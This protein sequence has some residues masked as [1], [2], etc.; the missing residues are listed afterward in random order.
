VFSRPSRFAR[1][2]RHDERFLAVLTSDRWLHLLHGHL[3]ESR[4]PD[5]E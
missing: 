5:G 1:R 3:L 2:R 4:P